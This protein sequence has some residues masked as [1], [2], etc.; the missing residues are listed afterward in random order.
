MTASGSSARQKATHPSPIPIPEFHWIVSCLCAVFVIPAFL[1]VKLPLSVNWS[2]LLTIYWVGLSLHSV[3]FAVLLIVIGLPLRQTLGPVWTHYKAQKARLVFFLVFAVVMILEFGLIS[4]FVLMVVAIVLTEIV[5]RTRG[6]LDAIVRLLKPLLLPSIYLFLGLVMVF[7]YND[8]IAI[9]RKTSAYDW[10]YLKMDSYLLGG[11]SVSAVAHFVI[12]RL[13]ASAVWSEVIY[14]GMFN[15]IGAGLILL[16]IYAG[17]KEA[18][19]YVGTLLTAYYLGLVLFFLWPSMGPFYTC[20]T[21]FS[22]FPAFL[23]T[24]GAQM[25]MA[26]KA[27]LLVT[28]RGLSQVDTDYF[29]AFP[30]L[31]IAQPLIV[32]W[33]LRKWKRMVIF[34][35]AYDVLLVPAILL[36]EWHYVVDIFGG[37]AIAAV[38]IALNRQ[39]KTHIL[40]WPSPLR[41]DTASVE[42]VVGPPAK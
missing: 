10:L 3:V 17:S 5:D 2:R 13:P 41:T 39:S 14:Y 33:Y 40:G 27:Q 11:T 15:Q 24:Y 32:A 25:G 34:L 8:L 1:A 38:A 21:H 36:L 20:P 18:A 9:V 37:V 6:D 42:F 16:A 31:H 35:V 29:I 12:R 4:G 23:R 7:A 30:C 19:R 22:E 26:A 28:H